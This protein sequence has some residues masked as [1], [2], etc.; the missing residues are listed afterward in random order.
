VRPDNLD[1]RPAAFEDVAALAELSART[2]R[3]TFIEQNDSA[4]IE[5]H[6]AKTFTPQA[7]GDEFQDPANTFLIAAV[8]PND[9]LIGYAKLRDSQAPASVLGPKPIELGRI[10]VGRESMGS[11]VGA[12]LMQACLDEAEQ[13]GYE[14]I[15]L[16]VWE[17]NPRA[18]VFY[19]R[20]NFTTVGSHIF[21]L[22]S[23][24]QTDLIMVRPV[25]DSNQ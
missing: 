13:R 19:D 16:G 6:I 17:A 25:R 12:A 5:A 2:F 4:Q 23:E 14:T 22:G 10:Y 7:L 3:D 1:I 9:E 11:G 15:W 18:I 21:M 20:W 24:K 8:D